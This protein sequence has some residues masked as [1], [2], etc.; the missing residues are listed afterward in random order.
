MPHKPPVPTKLAMAVNQ[1]LRN[2]GKLRRKHMK[3]KVVFAFISIFLMSL[4]F[5]NAVSA[6]QQQKR[7]KYVVAFQIINPDTFEV[8][9][10]GSLEVNPPSG[11]PQQ[12]GWVKSQIRS[13]IGWGSGS[14]YRTKNG[15]RQ[16]LV[17]VSINEIEL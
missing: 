10:S 12:E 4:V 6:Q 7:V 3:R 2:E 14:D 11:R 5:T 16:K 13:Q 15:V 9:S 8:I 17:F 1:T